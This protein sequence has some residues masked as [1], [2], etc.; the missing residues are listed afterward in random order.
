VKR[1]ARAAATRLP[2][3]ARLL[4]RLR[5]AAVGGWLSASALCA[6]S[7]GADAG[8][9]LA[10]PIDTRPFADVKAEAT[11]RLAKT[12]DWVV[13]TPDAVWVGTTGPKGV[14]RIDPRSNARVASVALPGD[15][16]AGLALGFGSLWV[17]LCA[18]PNALAR[19]DLA[20]NGVSIVPGLGP[21]AKE[22]GITASPDSVWLIVDAAGSLARIDPATGRVRQTI[23]VPAG[24]YNPLYS[25]GIA[26]VTRAA[27]AELT[28]VDAASGAV[29]GSTPTGPQPRFLTAG[30]GSIWTLNQG[31]GTLTRVDART[32]RVLAT[33]ALDTPGHGGDIG[34]AAGTVWTTIPGVPLTST[35]AATDRVRRRWPGR[36]GDSLAAG[37]DVLWL[38][39][40]DAGAVSRLRL[41]DLVAR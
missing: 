26:W 2:E 16:C 12:A 24:S 19:V 23:H 36:G 29:L 14:A 38:T 21:A 10:S 8:P 25:D 37:P 15:P 4:S 9:S 22:G 40:F 32:R 1:R 39:D 28:A 30:A 6:A 11:I 33:I 7:A 34:F 17:P 41:S 20:T 13:V 3:R 31:D 27:G 35:A 5:S 18:E